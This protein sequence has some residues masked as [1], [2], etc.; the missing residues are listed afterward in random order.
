MGKQR[1]KTGVMSG[2]VAIA[3][4]SGCMS[5]MA[6]EP[7]AQPEMQAF[8]QRFVQLMAKGSPEELRSVAS[9][10]FWAQSWSEDGRFEGED[11]FNAF[12]AGIY[13]KGDAL[14]HKQAFGKVLFKRELAGGIAFE[15][16]VNALVS[17]PYFLVV[18]HF[19]VGALVNMVGVEDIFLL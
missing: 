6:N 13:R 3:L 18:I 9:M 2:L 19:V 5:R 11:F 4:L 8:G 1:W 14:A 17:G 15:E 10:P 16:V 7:E 12:A